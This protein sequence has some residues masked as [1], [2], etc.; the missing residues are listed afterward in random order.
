VVIEESLL[1]VAIPKNRDGLLV[2]FGSEAWE[3]IRDAR[4]LLYG[5]KRHAQ[6][7]VFGL[8]PFSGELEELVEARFEKRSPS[9]WQIVGIAL[10][11]SDFREAGEWILRKLVAG[12]LVIAGRIESVLVHGGE[13]WK[14]CPVTGPV[15]R[16]GSR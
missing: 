4:G 3:A 11:A 12:D 14:H 1:S 7:D 15:G 8:E 6:V 2:F 9:G 5:E 10:S 13:A 16:R